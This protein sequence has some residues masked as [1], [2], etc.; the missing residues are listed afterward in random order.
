MTIR[1]RPGSRREARLPRKPSMHTHACTTSSRRTGH[2]QVERVPTSHVMCPICI[3]L[4][5]VEFAENEPQG[6]RSI[7]CRDATKQWRTLGDF[8][9]KRTQHV[10]GTC[11]LPQR[12]R[13]GPL[14]TYP[15]VHLRLRTPATA[16]QP[17]ALR[18]V[19]PADAHA[20]AHCNM[21][22]KCQPQ[23][24]Y[25]AGAPRYRPSEPDETVH[26]HF[27]SWLAMPLKEAAVG[28]RR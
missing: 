17:A 14:A 22:G 13:M 18:P 24:S 26:Y 3:G 12:K 9:E 7:G 28:T 16:S 25:V 23:T 20:P 5:N 15:A 10:N 4:I 19:L 2:L 8:P 1:Q 27:P 11:S 6:L 21:T